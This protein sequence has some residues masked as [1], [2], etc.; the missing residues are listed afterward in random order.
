MMARAGF[1]HMWIMRAVYFALCLATVLFGLVPLDT[2]P[3]GWAGPDLLLALTFAWAV[4]C[5][6]YVPAPLVAAVFLLADLMF[7]RPPGL[8]AALALLASERFRARA[9][10]LLPA[11]FL[12]EWLEVAAALAVM[13][14]L[15]RLTLGIVAVD[16]PPPSL[17]MSQMAATVAVYPLVVGFSALA[18]GVR[19]TVQ[20]DMLAPEAR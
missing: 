19:K 4:R 9:A 8:W 14:L 12:L 3:R 11:S 1:A 5:P 16:Q 15:Y 20:P 2:A 18:L 10:A 13:T 7:Q 17:S 6:G